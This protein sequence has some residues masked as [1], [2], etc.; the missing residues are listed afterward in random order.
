MDELIKVWVWFLE[1]EEVLLET[2]IVFVE[3][4]GWAGF[5]RGMVF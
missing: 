1:A 4:L 3:Y 5:I 2:V